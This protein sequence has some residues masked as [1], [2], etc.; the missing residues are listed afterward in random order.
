MIIIS[1]YLEI[2]HE[3]KRNIGLIVTI[4]G[5]G[6]VP[7]KV[8]ITIQ[9]IIDNKGKYKIEANVEFYQ[10]IR[11]IDDIFKMEDY[12]EL[13]QLIN[14]Y[15]MYVRNRPLLI[16]PIKK[17]KEVRVNAIKMIIFPFQ[18]LVR[19]YAYIRSFFQILW[20]N[21]GMLNIYTINGVA[22]S[23]SA[24]RIIART[25]FE[26]DADIL[27][28]INSNLLHTQISWHL[29]R[30]HLSN[31]VI[32]SLFVRERAIEIVIDASKHMVQPAKKAIW[33]AGLVGSGINLSTYSIPMI[34]NDSSLSFQILIPLITPIIWPLLA[35]VVRR[36]TPQ[37]ISFFIRRMINRII[38]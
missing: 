37:L 25:I 4:L 6:K 13:Q 23:T 26:L 17:R 31:V 1:I 11:R 27:T 9:Q 14:Y 5:R 30:L 15:E 19:R 2:T 21:S 7:L 34:L 12:S 28:A 20:S 16:E 22:D 18:E 33:Y 3:P 38:K 24:D 10:G 29:I 8:V 36:I 32:A 35:I